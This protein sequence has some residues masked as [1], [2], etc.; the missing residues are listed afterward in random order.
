MRESGTSARPRHEHLKFAVIE[1]GSRVV[2]FV[3]FWVFWSHIHLHSCRYTA[4][5]EILPGLYFYQMS[6]TKQERLKGIRD[7][8]KG[9][10]IMIDYDVYMKGKTWGE[11]H[12]HKYML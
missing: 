1:K 10:I 3:L 2:A 12:V 11:V 5:W 8:C 9:I 6:L 4:E 7:V